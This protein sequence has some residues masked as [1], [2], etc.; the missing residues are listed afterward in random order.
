MLVFIEK[1]TGT[2]QRIAQPVERGHVT[3]TKLSSRK[4]ASIQLIIF[5]EF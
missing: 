4:M 3:W 1:L 2:Q 5:V